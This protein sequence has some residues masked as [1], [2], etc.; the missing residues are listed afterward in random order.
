[1]PSARAHVRQLLWE[2]DH[3]G[4]AQDVSVEV[5]ELVTN[6]VVASSELWPAIA[7][8]RVWLGSDFTCVLVACVI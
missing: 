4:L 8:V 5:S 2:W 3:A 7:P 6:A 1:V